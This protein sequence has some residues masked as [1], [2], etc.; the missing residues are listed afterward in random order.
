VFR[1]ILLACGILSSLLYVGID[2]LAAVGYADY[3]SF[4]SQAISELAA[5]GAPTKH[6]VD[7]LFIA[8]DVL[9]IAF[10]VGVWTSPPRT[11]ALHLVGGLLIAIA[12][13]GL[14]WPPM[15]LRGTDD[16]SGDAPHIAVAGVVILLILL[17]IGAGA[18]LQGRSF[19]LYSCATLTTI[20][21]SGAW[22]GFAGS[23]L[24]AG[25]PTPW[26]GVAERINVGAYLVWV[27]VLAVMLLRSTSSSIEVKPAGCP[28]VTTP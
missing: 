15:Q 8:Y 1:K 23:R 7:P 5:V 28:A 26:L 4:T 18:S 10:G 21:V 9:L 14:M 19:L 3:H 17:T 20:L 11:R 12:V 13:V 24:A 22:T 2:V 27:L 16:V 6:L 25:E